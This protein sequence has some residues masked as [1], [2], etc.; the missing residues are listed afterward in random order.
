MK[1]P[2]NRLGGKGDQMGSP[3]NLACSRRRIGAVKLLVWLLGRPNSLR[4][5]GLYLDTMG[6]LRVV[7][8]SFSPRDLAAMEA[9]AVELVAPL[10]TR[11]SIAP[12]DSPAVL[13]QW[14]ALVILLAHV[15]PRYRSMYLDLYK[16]P[17]GGSEPV[18]V[19]SAP[20]AELPL[21]SHFHCDRS[22]AKDG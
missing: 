19:V 18:E 14:K 9:V 1:E 11:L 22:V 21:A 15:E 4:Q 12:V 13:I 10:P 20:R 6:L 2:K 17:A 7:H 3:V 8:V 5:L 16:E